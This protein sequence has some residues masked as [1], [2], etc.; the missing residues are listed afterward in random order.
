MCPVPMAWHAI[1][2]EQLVQKGRHISWHCAQIC[3]AA[4][5]GAAPAVADHLPI[6]H[7][8]LQRHSAPTCT[9]SACSDR[10]AVRCAEEKVHALAL[11]MNR[12]ALLA[13]KRSRL[14]QAIR[15]TYNDF[16]HDYFITD[17]HVFQLRV[18]PLLPVLALSALPMRHES[19]LA[20][21]FLPWRCKDM[22]GCEGMLQKMCH[23][24]WQGSGCATP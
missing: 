23:H 11:R 19:G 13:E 2:T 5:G 16:F 4:G 8:P 24:A 3:N 10:P 21:L 15:Q 22:C 6:L 14:L 12:S 1:C 7:W 9:G 20:W 17:D 18:S